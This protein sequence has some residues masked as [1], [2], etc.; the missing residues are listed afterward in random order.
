[1]SELHL[2][3][4]LVP[5]LPEIILAVVAIILLIAGAFTDE[6]AVPTL[7][8][9]AIFAMIGAIVAVCTLSGGSS[10]FDGAFQF[11]NFARY[12]KVLV[13][14]GGAVSIMMSMSYARFQSFSRFEYPVLILL[15]TVG[16]MLMISAS[17]MIAVYL[18]LE[19]QSL[20]IYIVVSI[21]RDSVRST[22]AGLKYF[23]LGALSSGML[24]YGI[25]LIYGFTGGTNFYSIA[26]TI[27]VDGAGLGVIFGLV[28]ILAGVAFKISAV[29]FHMWTPDVYE[30][31][32][33]PVTAFLAAAPKVAAMALLV[34]VVMEAFQPALIEWQQII[35]FLSVMSMILGAFA[36]IGQ[37]NIKRLMAYSS[38]GHIGYALIGLAAGTEQGVIGVVIYMTVYL[39]TTL[40]VFA[41]IIA[42]RRTDEGM[43]EDI[44]DLAG[45]AKTN[46][47]MAAAF[48]ALLFSLAG[49][50][51]LVGFFGKFYVFLAAVEADLIPLAIIGVLSSAVGCF[52]YLRIIKVMVFD[53][54]KDRLE[55]MAGE[56]RLVLAVSGGFS[57]LFFLVWTPILSAATAAAQ[58]L[59]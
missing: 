32:P 20:A 45:L 41:C 6:E 48:T 50:P 3:P 43:V 26:E 36:A 2:F 38:I 57:V 47:W 25:S 44:A 51:P 21:N 46:P 40:G 14:I 54:P 58:S 30:G 29:P 53:E 10:T 16:M 12:L 39:V 18:G 17:D 37:S 1:M 49:I 11:D 5:V 8:L 55:P 22:E 24:L 42:M 4:N 56:L 31:A 23:V 34:R 35:I 27:S 7:N 19:L 33:S 59:F 13:L 15:S 9:L 52:Y 28:F